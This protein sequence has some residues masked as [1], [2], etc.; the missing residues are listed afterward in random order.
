MKDL[1]VVLFGATGFTGRQTAA[2]FARHAPAGLKWAVA[3]RSADKLAAVAGS[4]GGVEA[5]VGDGADADAMSRLA[6]RARVVLTTAGPFAKYGD[7]LVAA[8][9]ANQAHYVD[10]T[11]ESPWVRSVIDRFHAKAAA[12][13]TR[14]V[15]CCGFDS[16]PSDIG[17]L[18]LVDHVR[19]ALGQPTV[20]VLAT[21]SLRGG[22]NGGTV[23]SALTMS[24]S[25]RGMGDVLLLNPESHRSEAERARSRDRRSVE[26]SGDH[27]RWLC[28]FVMAPVNTRIV[29][30]S[31]ALL[32][33]WGEGYAGGAGFTYDEAMETRSRLTAWS[34]TLGLGLGFAALRTRPGRA[35]ARRL[36]PS[37]GQGPS[38]QVMD[39][40]F[41]RVRLRAEAADGRVVWGTVAD[42]GDPGNRATVKMLCE[43]ALLLATTPADQLPGGSSRGGVLTPATA[44]GLP[45]VE[46]LRSA[47]MTLE[48]GAAAG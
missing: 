31:A 3:G 24:E 25:G 14:I 38:E 37:P 42:R 28:P 44:L 20:R 27:Q 29:R 30:R 1:D 35:I 15:P 23:D 41:Y 18:V 5:I 46:R 7:A 4:C 48:A 8:C 39:E 33:D 6:A 11:G 26:W 21:F 10:I 36:A 34:M 43:A 47:G 17:A 2:Y 16:V 40:G 13:G 32:D 9:A 19:R 22:I 12:D 45:Y